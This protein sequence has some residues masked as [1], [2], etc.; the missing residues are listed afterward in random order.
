MS[1]FF[2]SNQLEINPFPRVSPLLS[3]VSDISTLFTTLL[4]FLIPFLLYYIPYLTI[5]IP[6]HTYVFLSNFQSKYSPFLS[7]VFRLVYPFLASHLHYF[8][9]CTVRHKQQLYHCI[10]TCL[11]INTC[12]SGGFTC[13]IVI[14]GSPGSITNEGPSWIQSTRTQARI[15]LEVGFGG[16][17]C[18]AKI[19]R[20]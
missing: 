15:Y 11:L 4:F 1:I 7:S 14:K 5:F 8:P 3:V 19:G 20:A 6:L 17:N 10:F 12:V 13:R 2:R 16:C 18:K 9:W